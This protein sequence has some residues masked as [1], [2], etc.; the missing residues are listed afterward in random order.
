MSEIT[1]D[2][3]EHYTDA[4]EGY[5]IT[6][7]VDMIQTNLHNLT[8]QANVNQRRPPA[9]NNT[10]LPPDAWSQLSQD[11]RLVWMKLSRETKALILGLKPPLVPSNKTYHGRGTRTSML[12]NISTFEFLNNIDES[13]STP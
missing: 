3:E 13:Y 2:E 8:R 9:T 1:Q 5:D 7:S 6:T 12:H 10:R 4:E 11:D